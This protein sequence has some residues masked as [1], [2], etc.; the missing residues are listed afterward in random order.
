MRVLGWIGLLALTLLTAPLPPA[1]AQ[2][3]SA[4]A[5]ELRREFDARDYT[6]AEKR[7]LQLGL[8]ITGDY[9]GLLDGRWGDGSQRAL[10]TATAE[11]DENSRA[12]GIVR[13]G[14]VFIVASRAIDFLVSHD[15]DYRG[16][17]GNWLHRFLAP[18]GQFQPDYSTAF[19]ELVMTGH[20]IEITVL[21]SDASIALGLHQYFAEQ[22]SPAAD[23]Y[24]VRRADRLVTAEKRGAGKSYTRSDRAS[25]GYS[26]FT[27]IVRLLPGGDAALLDAVVASITLDPFAQIYTPNGALA[28][29]VDLGDRF[30]KAPPDPPVAPIAPEPVPG[31]PDPGAMAAAPPP[32]AASPDGEG[33]VDGVGTAF[34]INNT[35]LVTAKHVVEGC[36]SMSFIDGTPL[37]VVAMHPTLDLALL[38]SPQRSRDWI[39]VHQTGEARLGQRVIALGYPFYGTIT[40]ALNSTG[41]NV[42]AMVGPGDD[43]RLVTVTAAI[44]PGNSGGPLLALDGTVIGVVIA[45]I[46]KIA[47]AE[48]TG[49]IPENTNYAVTGRELLAFLEAEGASLPRQGNAPVEFDNG[50]PEVMQN[51]VLPVLCHATGQAG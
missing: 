48:A 21:T 35:D 5:D 8:A 19:D 28:S 41:G 33:S 25:D 37:A 4:L 39:A 10:E 36:A 50:V 42:S 49:S 14:H 22:I 12:D 11:F 3:R 13:D 32:S 26:W 15:L 23:P 40:T 44:H 29:L 2:S 6:A 38:S 43:N 7:L 17:A 9:I 31:L 27:T 34:F 30:V 51:A 45:T 47:V 1:S 20:G 16:G 46:N 24:F 18:P